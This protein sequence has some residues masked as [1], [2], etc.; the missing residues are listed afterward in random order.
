MTTRTYE[1][2]LILDT[3]LDAE[4]IR[5]QLEKFQEQILHFGGLVRKWDSWGKKR[6]TYEIQHKQ[7][8]Y[9]AVVVFDVEPPAV[10]TLNR[11]LRLSPYILRHLIVSVERH[12]IPPV[13]STAEL[14][15]ATEKLEEEP[16]TKLVEEDTEVPEEG[17]EE[18]TEISL[19]TEENDQANA[20]VLLT[21]KH[22]PFSAVYKAFVQCLG[23]ASSK[24]FVLCMLRGVPYD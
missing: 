21:K 4:K 24:E 15:L 23:S 3:G 11:Y 6:M 16:V 2:V 5:E 12:R 20:A 17:L 19:A 22:R 8:G 14:P 9:Y 13:E 7:Y 10:K 18:P 1:G